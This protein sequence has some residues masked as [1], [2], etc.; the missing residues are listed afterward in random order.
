MRVRSRDLL[1]AC[2]IMGSNLAVKADEIT[3]EQVQSSFT[4]V[5]RFCPAE[6][7][8]LSKHYKTLTARLAGHEVARHPRIPEDQFLAYQKASLGDVIYTDLFFDMAAYN[9][10]LKEKH[11]ISEDFKKR[12]LAISQLSECLSLTEQDRILFDQ[13][14]VTAI[15]TGEIDIPESATADQVVS[16]AR[17]KLLLQINA[18]ECRRANEFNRRVLSIDPES[19]DVTQQIDIIIEDTVGRC[20]E[21][22]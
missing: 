8:Y 3:P 18:M 5:Q 15:K 4:L 11:P 2:A 17:E 21:A 1:I 6:A 13:F 20:E 14:L 19:S 9:K 22:G 16:F 12:V 7:D 10:R